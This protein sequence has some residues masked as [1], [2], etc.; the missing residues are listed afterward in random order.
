MDGL[1]QNLTQITQKVFETLQFKG[2]TL[3]MAE[4]A[5][6]GLA[7]NLLT[8]IPGASKVFIG[9]VVCYTAQSKNMLLD[10]P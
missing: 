2:L 5:T 4:S 1:N 10:V 7:S 6:G 9:G 8:D 3:S